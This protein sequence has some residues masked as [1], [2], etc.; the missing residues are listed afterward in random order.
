MGQLRRE[1]RDRLDRRLEHA[2]TPGCQVVALQQQT[3]A[4]FNVILLGKGEH[5]LLSVPYVYRAAA[6]S[7]HELPG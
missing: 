3:I 5:S 2:P 7:G 1:I 4:D 6:T